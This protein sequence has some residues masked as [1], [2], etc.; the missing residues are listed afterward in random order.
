MLVG[1]NMLGRW[2]TIENLLVMLYCRN[3]KSTNMDTLYQHARMF[4][5]R[6]DMLKY[7]HIYM[8]DVVYDKFHATYE[9][10]EYLRERIRFN[11][12][13]KFSIKLNS[14]TPW[15]KLTRESIISKTTLSDV[16]SPWR[17]FY[18][19]EISEQN[20]IEN[21]KKY[22]NL[23][24]KLAAFGWESDEQDDSYYVN[25]TKIKDISLITVM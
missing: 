25:N 11:P 15:L 3:S 9:T 7:M 19:N 13:D 21:S 4:W 5:Y 14:L 10:D 12:N 20:H 22:H 16:F 24:S 1:G 8:P 18:P 2:V 17:Q 23:K 6:Q